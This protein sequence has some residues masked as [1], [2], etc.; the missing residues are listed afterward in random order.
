MNIS[1]HLGPLFLSRRP[2]TLLTA[3]RVGD[4]FPPFHLCP[5][6]AV[7][8][9][10]PLMNQALGF[11]SSF[12]WLNRALCVA[13]GTATLW[14]RP[15]AVYLCPSGP[16]GFSPRGGIPIPRG[17]A[18]GPP[19]SMHPTGPAHHG[20]F[21]R[22]R[23]LCRAHVP[24]LHQSLVTYQGWFLKRG[25]ISLQLP[26]AGW[27]CDCPTGTCHKLCATSFSVLCFDTSHTRES[28]RPWEPS[29]GLRALPPGP[30]AEPPR[31]MFCL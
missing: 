21:Q 4:T 17:T 14:L 8:H 2:S 6:A 29:A 19:D 3:P 5:A 9:V 18:A 20:R 25:V 23:L 24:R 26:V 13:K 7:R 16:L 10:S 27:L 15:P 12:S 30:S 28:A 11:S 31:V 1:H 22:S